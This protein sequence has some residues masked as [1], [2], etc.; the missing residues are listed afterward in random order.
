[1]KFLVDGVEKELTVKDKNG[2]EWTADWMDINNQGYVHYDKENNIYTMSKDNY[3]WWEGILAEKE[4]FEKYCS[5]YGLSIDYVKNHTSY[6]CNDYDTFYVGMLS[7]AKSYVEECNDN[8][9]K[10]KE[11]QSVKIAPGIWIMNGNE[12][13]KETE[14][15]RS[16]LDTDEISDGYKVS[17][18]IPTQLYMQ[19]DDGYFS[20]VD[21]DTVMSVMYSM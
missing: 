10:A 2:I 14:D 12:V 11:G 20:A 4:E 1:M 13:L 7:E 6:Y 5:D 21:K 9:D 19:T 8:V 3:E 15:C 16:S 17:D 18:I